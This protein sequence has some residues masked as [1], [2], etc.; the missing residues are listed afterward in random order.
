MNTIIANRMVDNYFRFIK[1]WDSD[2]KKKLITKLT[3][4]FNISSIDKSDFSSCFGTWEDSR[5]ATEIS[6]E[7]RTDRVNQK[8]IE[9]F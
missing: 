9:E 7:I 5:S 3:N 6:L 4:S 8:D 1:Y 2:S